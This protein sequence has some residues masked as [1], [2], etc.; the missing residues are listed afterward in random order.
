MKNKIT[1]WVLL[2]ACSVVFSQEATVKT[3]RNDNPIRYDQQ[4]NPRVVVKPSVSLQ[5]ATANAKSIGQ[6]NPTVLTRQQVQHQGAYEVSKESSIIGYSSMNPERM[7]SNSANQKAAAQGRNSETAAPSV[8]YLGSD[9]PV[10]YQSHTSSI[11][12]PLN[13]GDNQE[14]IAADALYRTNNPIS[15]ISPVVRSNRPMSDIT[16]TAGATESF[17][18]SVGDHFFDPGGPGGSSTGGTAGNYPNCGCDTQTTLMGVSEIEFQFFSVFSTFDYLR[19]YDGTDATGTLLYDN[20]AG[21]NSGDITLADMIDSNGSPTF[22]STSGNFFFFF[23]ASAVVDYG[24]WDVLITAAGGGGPGGNCSEE[25]PNDMTFENGFNCSSA[26]DFKVANDVTVAPDENFTLTNITASIFAVGGIS[27]VDVTYYADA[28]GLPGAVIGSETSVTIDSQAVIGTN[29][30]FDVNE[31]N[32]SVA[33]FLFAGQAGAPTTYWIELSVTDGGATGSVFWVVT[34]STSVGNKAAQFETA[35]A[36]ADPLMDGVYKWEGNCEPIGTTGDT[37]SEENPNDM[38]FENGFNCSSTSDF[39]TANDVTVAPDENFTLTNITAS[40]FA[41]GGITNVDVNYYSDAA[42]L[43]GA[44]IGSETSVTIDSQTVIGTNFGF[45]VNEIELSV[46]PFLFAGQA[47]APTT[48]WIELSVTDGGATGSVFWVV[49]SSTS[50]G[51]MA[52]QFDGGWTIGDPLMDGVYMWEGDCEPLGTTGDTCSEENPN[53]MTFENGFNCSSASD[54]MTANDVTVAADEDFTLTNITASIFAVGGITNVDVNYYNDASGL[55]GT[56]IGSEAAVTIDSQTVIGTN[57]GFDVNEIELSVAPFLFAGQA[58]APTTYWIE[59]SV[60]DGGATGSVFWVVTSSTSVGNP[61]AQFDGGWTIGDPLMDGVYMWEGICEPMGNTGDDCSE[62]NPNDMTFE[63][64]FNCSSA[65]DFMTANDI[66]VAAG[67]DF[68]LTNITASIFAVGG[69][70][71]VDVNYYN[72]ASGLPG[73]LI[74]SETSVVIDNQTVIGTN[75]GFDVNE[76]ELSVNP[77]MFSG[78]PGAPTTYW[79]ELSVTDG[80]ATGSVFW[81]VTSSTAVGNPAAQFDG[82]WTIG[83]P[84]MDGVYKW[85][86]ICS[87][88]V[89]VVENNTLSGFNFYPNPTNEVINLSASKNIDSVVLFNM[90]GQRILSTEVGATT[91]H[92]NVGG[93]ATGTYI[94]KVTVDG[95]TGTYKVIKN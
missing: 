7:S 94:M 39:K 58:G 26:S 90:L 89:G 40:I 12:Y 31:I 41:V 80:G 81:V 24:G 5:P 72:D 29:F 21:P 46:A 20:N 86:G 64:G 42:G 59:L 2:L 53:D 69:I 23:H 35:W 60:T 33:P 51:N 79:I 84:V 54:F 30:G 34:S 62:E 22:T 32:L 93:L 19:I 87:P 67:E 10:F 44:L 82:G 37:C 66:T 85:E 36:I 38:T 73:T 63:N 95:Q 43:P 52:A 88:T 28:A 16:P 92:L 55:P 65:S 14:E 56:L 48:Y 13:Q 61:A 75:F 18:P 47:G 70:T 76:I 25:N 15:V 91:S 49:T 71:N 50:V 45:D 27:N 74:G 11:S 8:S 1:L 78:Q 68:T 6:N 9:N 83:D 3:N 77:F 57:F 4:G 17:T